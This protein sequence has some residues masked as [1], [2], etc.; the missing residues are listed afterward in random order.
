MKPLKKKKTPRPF[1]WNRMSPSQKWLMLLT[2]AIF[3]LSTL[4]F[5]IVLFI[6]L[7]PTFTILLTS[8]QNTPKLII[9]GGFN[10]AGVLFYIFNIF[11]NY[12]LENAFL[13]VSNVF[14]LIIM[15]SSAALG[16]IIYTELPN[17]FIFFSNNSAER[18]LKEIDQRLEQLTEEWGPE[19]LAGPN[20][21][22]KK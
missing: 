17:L 15:L 14:N 22:N 16:L 13:V 2:L 18:R 5:T 8:P 10:F 20:A 4:P 19:I 9:V 21:Q 11:G 12:S 7:L 6:G 3:L 1:F